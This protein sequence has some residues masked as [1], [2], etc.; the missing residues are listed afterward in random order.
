MQQI[1]TYIRININTLRNIGVWEKIKMKKLWI[2]LFITMVMVSWQFSFVH[3]RVLRSQI[4]DG[5]EEFKGMATFAL[6]SNN[7][8]TH[9]SARS[10]AFRLYSGPSNKGRGH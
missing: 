5:C 1:V 3:C 4:T 2:V 10:L 6:S 7:S 9:Y 8:N